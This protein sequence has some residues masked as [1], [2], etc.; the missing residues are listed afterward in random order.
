MPLS[1]LT[2]FRNEYLA[3]VGARLTAATITT[4]TDTDLLLQSALLKAYDAVNQFDPLGPGAVS[5]LSIMTGAE[6]ETWLQDASN[7]QSFETVVASSTAMTAVINDTAAWATIVASSTAMTAVINDTAAWATIVASSTAMTAVAASSTAMTAVAASD[8]ASDAV[9]TNTVSRLAIYNDNIA[10][11]AFQANPNQVQRQIGIAGRTT[12]ASA[13]VS[14]FEY[15][16]NG[17][18]VIL[19]RMWTTGGSEN[20]SLNFARGYTGVS[21]ATTAGIIVPITGENLGKTT[22]AFGHTT[23]YAD[24]GT[25]PAASNDNANVVCAANGLKRHTWSIVGSTTQ[26]VIYITV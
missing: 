6:L 16:A 20:P 4:A 22:V 25:Y 10:L 19:L 1:D 3:E 17:T 7:R 23:T 26:N 11:S 9:F 14:S 18:K 24:S 15:V 13:T 5:I 8:I 12:S 2:N 21:N